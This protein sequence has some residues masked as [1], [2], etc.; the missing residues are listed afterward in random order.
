MQLDDFIVQTINAAVIKRRLAVGEREVGHSKTRISHL[1][2][3]LSAH[4]TAH[5]Y[6]L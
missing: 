6:V 3:L 4:T 2:P 5:I 1:Y